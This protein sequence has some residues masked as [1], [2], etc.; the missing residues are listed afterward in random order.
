MSRARQLA[1][2]LLVA[3]VSVAALGL[4]LRYSLPAA[5]PPSGAPLPPQPLAGRQLFQQKGC[6]N[7][8]GADAAGGVAGPALRQRPS[9]TTPAR[10]VV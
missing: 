2:W 5:P 10:L 7:C 8:H 9:L 3:C 6:A 1:L 4:A